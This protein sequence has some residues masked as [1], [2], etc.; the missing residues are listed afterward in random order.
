MTAP[1]IQL[2]ERIDSFPTHV[3][4]GYQVRA[5]RPMPFGPSLVSGG[6]NFSVFSSS[7]A[8]VS[9]VL[10]RHGEREPLAELPFPDEFR[11]GAVWAMT[12]F[13]L[14]HEAIDYGYRVTGP[15]TPG[16]A[17][18]FDPSK[19]L[20]DPYAKAMTG[21]DVW[22]VEPDW[23]D[24]YPYRSRVALC[25]FDWEGD[26]PLRLP[27]EDLV[28]YELHVRGFTR[29]L[30][31]G[32]S[33]PGTYAGLIEKI[34]YL[35]SLGVNCVELMP[36]FE[37]DEFENSR[38]NPQ[39]GEQLLNYWGYSTVGFFA[40]K[41][42]YAATGRF[43]MQVDEFKNLVKELHSAGIEVMLDVVF[44]H[45]A[46]GNENGPTI[47][48]RG[49]DNATYY[50]LT[51]EGY[52]YNFSGT[53]NTF[54]CNNPVVRDYVL[55]CLR[56]WASEFHIDGFR[57][58]L[59]AILDR[60]QDGTPL[61][62]P[63]L[64]ESLSHD[65]VLRDCVLVAE[66]WDAGGLYQVGSFPNYQRWSEWNG[67]YRDTLRRFLKGDSGT[68][69]ELA[70]RLVGSPDLYSDRGAASSI[71]FITCHDGFTLA[72]MVAYDGKHNDANGED[73]RDGNNDNDSWN[74]GA[75][76]TTDDVEVQALRQRQIKNAM[77]LLLTSQGIPMILAGDEVGR[78]QAGNNN[79]YCHDSPLTWFDWSLVESNTGLLRFV[80][81]CIAFRMAHPVLRDRRHPIGADLLG[82]GYG[83]P[84]WH[85]AMAWSPDWGSESRLLGMLRAGA[86]ADGAQDYVYV[87]TNAGWEPQE[88]ELPVLPEGVHWHVFA[89]TC[90]PEPRDV[91]HPGAEP[92]LN[93]GWLNVGPRSVVVLVGRTTVA[94]LEAVWTADDAAPHDG[95][96]DTFQAEEA[97]MSFST[98]L[99]KGGRSA[100]ITLTGELDALAAPALREEVE[101]AATGP[102]EQLVLDMSDVS[103]LSSAGLRTL[104]FAR[105][106][107]ADDVRIV[108][109]G[110]NDAVAR[111]IRLVGFQYSV[112]FSDRLPD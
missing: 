57:F 53:G 37:F 35:K 2:P 14:D 110:A 9:L 107:M 77:L 91:N 103:Y 12:V 13:G 62:N 8:A 111:T 66:A 92:V 84:S 93:Q 78:S 7:A 73:N 5:G 32:V 6:V 15:A 38:L 108:L 29:D 52:Y 26:Q 95:G 94:E 41:A 88:V 16:P 105:Q 96:A 3:I 63:P 25:D 85:G 56:Y 33:H 70:T 76:G 24:P 30:S 44:N 48:F 28:I 54:N 58:D 99:A 67:K 55:S 75:E 72:D 106:K 18:R 43:G 42:G 50:M 34:P 83:D 45:T 4:D 101:R 49:L 79:A 61:Q 98:N 100:V 36:I 82:T 89:D 104:V 102:L 90:A 87:L 10:F 23:T 112:E 80:R 11:I 22:G 39:T 40:P 60:G 27:A 20:A 97:T 81:D 51:P 17:D 47:N 86:G 1:A 69:G 31:A 46:E 68:I 109:V 64:L 19:I 21:R 71:N 65:P 59:A 74:C